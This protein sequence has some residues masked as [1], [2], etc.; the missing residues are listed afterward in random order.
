MHPGV[1]V[2]R[3]SPQRRGHSP[4]AAGR[5]HSPHRRAGYGTLA[6]IFM[7][8]WTD[9][10]RTYIARIARMLQLPLDDFPWERTNGFR[11]VY[12]VCWAPRR[13]TRYMPQPST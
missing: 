13:P 11:A 3:A 7:E 2:G 8:N 12:S 6:V 1:A 10:G 5:L 9:G 4:L